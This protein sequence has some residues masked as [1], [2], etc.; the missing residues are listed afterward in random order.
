VQEER[1]KERE[2]DSYQVDTGNPLDRKGA[3][4]GTTDELGRLISKEH[5]MSWNRE[6]SQTWRENTTPSTSH[7]TILG[8]YSVCLDCLG[9]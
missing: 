6:G 7:R 4:L 5:R 8:G 3:Q 2:R 1:V 9:D